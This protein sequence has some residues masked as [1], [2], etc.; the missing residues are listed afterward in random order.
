[1]EKKNYNGWTNYETWNVALWLNNEPSTSEYLH[2][3]S[4]GPGKTYEK[5][6]QLQEFVEDMNPLSEGASMFH[7]LLSAAIHAVNWYEII[8]NHIE[9]ENKEEEDE[10]L[11]NEEG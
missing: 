5:A 7:D 10:D 3:L 11:N 9:E 4:N 6:R 8:E 2:D 1:M